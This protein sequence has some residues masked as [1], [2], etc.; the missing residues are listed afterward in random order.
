MDEP[1]G[2]IENR[3]G[4]AS[5]TARISPAVYCK[6]CPGRQPTE[7]GCAA[8]GAEVAAYTEPSFAIARGDDAR[9]GAVCCAGAVTSD[10]IPCGG[11]ACI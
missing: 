1:D 10:Q 8:G 3:G 2:G 9:A 11:C 7:D 5:G 4:G 6:Q